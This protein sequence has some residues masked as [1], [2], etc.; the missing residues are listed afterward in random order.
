MLETETVQSDDSVLIDQSQ[1]SNN[2]PCN[3]AKIDNEQQTVN[4]V[5]NNKTKPLKRKSRGC[6][7]DKEQ[8]VCFNKP[9]PM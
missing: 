4:K 6:Y 9:I 5:V 7:C 1:Q 3:T 2:V 8:L